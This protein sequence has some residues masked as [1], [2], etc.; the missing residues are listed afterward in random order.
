MHFTKLKLSGFK[1]FID[2]TEL[3][4]EPGMTGIVGPNGCGKSNIV[5]ALRWVM[6]ET[7]PK[8]VR[9]GAMDDVI[10]S[11]TDTRAPRNVAEVGLVID[12]DERT[13]PAAFNEH[14]EI[15]VVRRIDRGEGSSY[16]VNGQE[17]RARDV[18]LLFADFATG[19]HSSALVA[20]G[21]INDIINAKPLQRRSILEEASGITGLHA[22][23][24]EAELRLRGAETN[25]ERL[26]DVVG[27]LETQLQGLKRQSR[28]ANRYRRVSESL[29]QFEALLLHLRWTNAGADVA[30]A[31]RELAAA[32]ARVTELTREA[33]TATTEQAGAAERLPALRQTEA[34]TAAA[35]HRL[36]VARDGLEAE[37]RRV[38]ETRQD[39]LR[40]REQ[41]AADVVRE[42]TLATDAGS[43]IARLEEERE[44]L[45]A[46]AA[47]DEDAERAAG[48]AMAE[49]SAAV[50]AVEERLTRLTE[51]VAATEAQR[52]TLARRSEETQSRIGR[53]EVQKAEAERQRE[54]LAA[55]TKDSRALDEAATEAK[56]ARGALDQAKAEEED[57]ERAREEC[58]QRESE[59]RERLQA[60][61][62]VLARL[63][64]EDSA[65]RELLAQVEPALGPAIADGVTVE[66]G[67]EA[68]LGAALGDDLEA[69]QNADAAV[70]WA[71][72]GPLAE[73]PPLPAGAEPLDRF[74][75]A[76]PALERRLCQVGVVAPEQGAALRAQLRPGQCLVSRDGA[77]WRWDGFTVASEAPT[78]AATRLKQRNR[79]STLKGELATAETARLGA[80]DGA[81]Q[82]ARALQTAAQ[83]AGAARTTME[84]ATEALHEA[85]ERH[86]TLAANAA[87]EA[88][89][90]NAMTETA[91]RLDAELA[92]SR[93]EFSEAQAALET[94]TPPEEGRA[95]IARLRERLV[96]LRQTYEESARAHDRTAR[97]AAQRTQR[98]GE[99][100]EQHESWR[101]RADGTAE[102]LA[103]LT[104]RRREIETETAALE[105]RP[106]EI[107]TQRRTLLDEIETTERARGVA[108][109]ALAEGEAALA[110]CDRAL[111]T[112][113][114]TLAAA[115][116]D[117]VRFEGLRDQ[118]EQ[119]CATVAAQIADRLACPA[120]QALSQA[121]M[122]EETEL[123][124]AEDVEARI[125]RLSRERDNIGPVNLRA[126]AEAQELEQQISVMLHER[127]DLEAAI[128]RLRQGIG[129][130]NREGRERVLA[131]FGEIDGHFRSLFTSLFGGGHAHLELVDS[132]D[133][134]EAGLEVMASPPGKRLQSLSLLSG[135]EKAL[136]A[137]ALLFAAFLTNPAP[138]CVLDEV[139]APLDDSNVGRFCS[140]VAELARK[141][142]T[143]FIVV[144]H[145]RMTMARV[146]RLFGVTMAERGISQLVSVDLADA[147]R[148]RE[149]A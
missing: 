103:E 87:A 36:A 94:V 38:A 128:A 138:I 126:E 121:G 101:A 78:A 60:A 97:E 8:Q 50:G 131:A 27:A 4:I 15:D 145:H 6:G 3:A 84:G 147:D 95:E 98:L 16:R 64:A 72:L 140:L 21:R 89:R 79:L 33:A 119:A 42:E 93:R 77:L 59:A 25:L 91:A 29:R 142:Q 92:E 41:I 54:T 31:E 107:A 18:Q 52:T 83:A 53:L 37:E 9:G 55:Q 130:L 5:E 19:A 116:E 67:Y 122:A 73:P 132:E 46:A 108:A 149:S 12:N 7:S 10:F 109:D 141:T 47:G 135:G 117:R 113:E 136:T 14:T 30:D 68:A 49:A 99:L 76:P 118:A 148:W 114:H 28:Q 88:S 105:G 123:P 139:D 143:R 26:E 2:P 96:E 80:A 56:R 57:A 102:R 43:A 120:D 39:L 85:R 134:L 48:A 100:A 110:Q 34:A 62:A 1:S 61:E 137:L 129:S 74:V 125:Q 58:R 32:N 17:V 65:I 24:H 81:T 146:D 66:P 13:A 104:A 44:S 45:R 70:H 40:R 90:L 127:T 144:T 75:Q 111:K 112:A 69:P 82:A 51:E 106:A 23:R 115:R 86:A 124:T 11:G 22:R 35:L 133:P 20:Q 71:A 63:S